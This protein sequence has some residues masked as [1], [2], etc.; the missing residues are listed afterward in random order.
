MPSA[1][2][3]A[4]LAHVE[5]GWCSNVDDDDCRI[6]TGFPHRPQ[7]VDDLAASWVVHHAATSPRGA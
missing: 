4:A 7:A 3:E 5:Y 1:V 2:T 6:L